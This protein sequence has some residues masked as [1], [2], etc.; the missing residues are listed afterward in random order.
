[1]CIRDRPYIL[2]PVSHLSPDEIDLAGGREGLRGTQ[3]FY[4]YRNRRLVIW[5]TWFKLVPKNEFFKLTRVQ[6]DIPNTFDELWA[7]DIKKSVAYPPDSIRNRLRQLIPHFA[8]TSRKTITYPGRKQVSR[9]FVPLWQRLEPSHGSFKYELNTEH[10]VIQKLSARLDTEDQKYFQSLLELFGEALP[11]D[12]IYADMCSDSRG[13]SE[14]D[15]ILGLVEI[16]ASLLEVT[17]FSINEIFNI[18]PLVRYPQ[19]HEKLRM[20][21]DK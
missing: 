10:A 1:M 2:P 20:E 9:D 13:N 19:H 5:G 14:S 16:A 21:L 15:T 8:D 6:V 17:G 18:D 3:G 4:V 7:L 11:F 12:S